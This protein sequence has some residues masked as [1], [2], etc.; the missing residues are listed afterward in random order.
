MTALRSAV[1]NEANYVLAHGAK[2]EYYEIRPVNIAAIRA[3][4]GTTTIKTDCSGSVIGIYA[5]AGAPDPSG[6]S[7]AGYGNTESLYSHCEHLPYTDCQPGDMVDVGTHADGGQTHVYLVLRRAGNDLEVFSHGGPLG[8]PPKTEMLS[9]VKNY[10]YSSGHVF[11]GL[12]ALPLAE[13]AP[14]WLV[15]NGRGE[16]LASTNHPV[17]W[18][19]GHPK[20]FRKWDQVRFVRRGT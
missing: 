14:S 1:V 15:L 4:K 9:S 8:H 7:Y 19:M 6:Y 5:R 16:R 2:W 11:T 13:K 10:W 17:R 20:S 18:A 12:R 3:W